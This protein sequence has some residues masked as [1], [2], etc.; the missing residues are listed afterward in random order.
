MAKTITTRY[1]VAEHL[2][3]PEE[4]ANGFLSRLA[5]LHGGFA[6][7]GGPNQS[8]VNIMGKQFAVVFCASGVVA[9]GKFSKTKRR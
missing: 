2:R 7:N 1:D 4:I 5:L 9:F 3:T 8:G 6:G